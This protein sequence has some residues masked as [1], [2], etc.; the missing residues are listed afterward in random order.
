MAR[1]SQYSSFLNSEGLQAVEAVKDWGV[2]DNRDLNRP[3]RPGKSLVI[4]SG[5]WYHAGEVV[6]TH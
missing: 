5:P 4:N 2:L 1:V 6:N 3:S